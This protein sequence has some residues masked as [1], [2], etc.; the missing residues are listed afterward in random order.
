MFSIIHHEGNEIKSRNEISFHTHIVFKILTW[1]KYQVLERKNTYRNAHV[2]FLEVKYDTNTLKSSLVLSPEADLYI[3]YDTEFT[4][5]NIFP[6]Q[7][8]VL[9]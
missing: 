7:S 2:V 3:H 1:L 4:L 6:R 8:L 9:A 5:L